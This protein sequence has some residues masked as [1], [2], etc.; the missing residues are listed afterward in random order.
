M[1]GQLSDAMVFH[2][3][4]Y[5]AQKLQ[6]EVSQGQEDVQAELNVSRAGAEVAERPGH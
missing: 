1:L 4:V 6:Q 3:A 5:A 2:L